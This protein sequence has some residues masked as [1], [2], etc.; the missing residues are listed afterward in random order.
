MTIKRGKKPPRHHAGHAYSLNDTF[1]SNVC[2]PRL[3]L[4]TGFGLIHE[5]AA[6][7]LAEVVVTLDLLVANR[8][9]LVPLLACSQSHIGVCHR[10]LV[11][12]APKTRRP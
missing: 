8:E 9:H 3:T 2:S 6:N 7:R 11:G 10:L 1:D 12:L 5:V 4:K